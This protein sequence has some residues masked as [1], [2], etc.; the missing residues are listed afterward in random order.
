MKR[1]F[2]LI[3]LPALDAIIL[4]LL[5]IAWESYLVGDLQYLGSTA[6]TAAVLAAVVFVVE[7][8]MQQIVRWATCRSNL[9]RPARQ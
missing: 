3:S 4:G 7:L 9:N 1:I 5:F 6:K 8:I 2:P